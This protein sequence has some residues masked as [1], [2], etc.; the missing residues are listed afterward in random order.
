[1]AKILG[2]LPRYVD[3]FLGELMNTKSCVG[4][5]WKAVDLRL[6]EG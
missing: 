2:W 5:G 3:G 1:M 6:Y 4:H